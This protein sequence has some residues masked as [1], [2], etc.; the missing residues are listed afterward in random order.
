[1]NKRIR[2]LQIQAF[3]LC[4]LHEGNLHVTDEVFEKFAQ[5]L[6]QECLNIADKEHKMALEFQWDNDD[7]AQTIK[8]SIKERFGVE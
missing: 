7:T 8:D 5:L 6:V 4:T 3:D 2:E 1:M